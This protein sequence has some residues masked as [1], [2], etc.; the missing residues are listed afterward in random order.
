MSFQIGVGPFQ[1][2]SGRSVVA[3]LREDST[4][5]GLDGAH[6]LSFDR[7]G[8]LIRAFWERRSIGRS[9]DNRFI[10]KRRMGTLPGSDARRE[11]DRPEYRALCEIISRELSAIHEALAGPDPDSPYR[12]QENAAGTRPLTEAETDAQLRALKAGLRLDPRARPKV[13]I[14]DIRDFIY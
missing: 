3:A 1:S 11:L 14:Y 10:E 8:R 13:A 5:F 12:Q 6:S 2:V 4:T 9:L 7:A